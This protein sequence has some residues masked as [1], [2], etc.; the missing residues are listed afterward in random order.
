MEDTVEN[1]L[2]A[3]VLDPAKVT[4]SGLTNA[5]GIAGIML[6]TQ[7]AHPPCLSPLAKHIATIEHLFNQLDPGILLEKPPSQFCTLSMLRQSCVHGAL[8]CV[9][10]LGCFGVEVKFHV[11]VK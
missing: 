4:R 10:K 1:L 7:V 3:G 9:C 8:C 2:D 11:G 5:C 6:T